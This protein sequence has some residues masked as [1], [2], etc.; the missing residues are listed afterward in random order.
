[1]K[2]ISEQDV[3][4]VIEK[5]LK[6]G[7]GSIGPDTVAEEVEAWDSLGHLSILTGL[8]VLFDGRIADIG[9]IADATS[10]PK[11]LAALR[12]HSLI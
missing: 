5:A 4:G 8:D 11:I 2:N 3:L 7:P 12:Q 6:T 9:E 10:V 1:M